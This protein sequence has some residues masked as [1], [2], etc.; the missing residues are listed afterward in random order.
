MRGTVLCHYASPYY[1]PAK[2]HEYY[3][4]HKKLKGRRTSTA[5]LNEEGRKAAAY[6]KKQLYDER[7]SK[8]EEKKNATNQKINTDYE[9]LESVKAQRESELRQHTEQSQKQIDNIRE[10]LS[11]MTEHQKQMSS[12]VLKSQIDHIRESNASQRAKVVEDISRLRSENSAK[13]QALNEQF[14]SDRSG[15]KTEYE[16]KYADE[17]DKLKSESK[18]TQN[19]SKS[20]KDSNSSS[21]GP[22]HSKAFETVEKAFKKS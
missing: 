2:A 1:D 7:D 13:R 22:G 12:N 21:S 16:N 10:R 11:K 15:L 5:G 19:T 4:E 20:K 17:L 6:V 8:I 3:E 18:Y 9:N 14:R